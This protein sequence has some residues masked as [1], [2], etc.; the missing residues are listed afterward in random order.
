MLRASSPGLRAAIGFLRIFALLALICWLGGITFSVGWCLAVVDLRNEPLAG[1]LHVGELLLAVLVLTGIYALRTGSLMMVAIFEDRHLGLL[2]EGGDRVA[3][4]TW[5]LASFA[6]G[7]SSA[8][9]T[10]QGVVAVWLMAE[11]EPHDV[12]LAV[13]VMSA[14]LAFVGWGFLPW[15]WRRQQL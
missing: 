1:L 9:L 11:G 15:V 3:K 14:L 4:W 10:L 6:V 5:G 13:T 8:M 12:L 2:A 7:V